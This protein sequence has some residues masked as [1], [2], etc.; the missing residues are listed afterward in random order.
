MKIVFSIISCSDNIDTRQAVL[1]K[2]WLNNICY[3]FASDCVTKD[4]VCL[5]TLRGHK[6]G[7]IKQLKAIEYAY[8][9][10]ID[11]DWF[12][13]C[14]DDTYVN[15]H[16]LEKYISIID[17]NLR[18]F[19]LLFSE[20]THPLNPIWPYVEKGFQYYSGGAGFALRNDLIKNIYNNTAHVNT[21]YGDVLMGQLLKGENLNNC[22]LLNQDN[23]Y[24]LDHSLDDIK[25]SI[26]YH[27]MNEK[28]MI[29]LHNAVN[30]VSIK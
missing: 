30:M 8:N 24:N 3:Y 5:T 26:S 6:S 15:I 20:E 19:G 25:L 10:Y 11:Y 13:F 1:K 28:S 2:T 14:D 9:K 17:V 21:G 18:S 12:F 29:D 23:P 4:N 22:N 7:E 16:N 27:Y